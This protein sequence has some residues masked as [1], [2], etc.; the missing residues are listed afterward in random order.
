MKRLVGWLLVVTLLLR[1]LLM[2][3]PVMATFVII[4]AVA[5]GV[6]EEARWRAALGLAVALLLPIAIRGRLGAWLRTRRRPM[7]APDW[8]TFVSLANLVLAGG[9]CFGFADQAGRALRRRGDWFCGESNGAVVRGLRAGLAVSARYLERFDP[10]LEL[11]PVV[12]PPDPAR[13]P[14]GPELPGVTPPEALPTV[15]GWFHPLAGPRRA[16]PL[17]E[18]RR[19][20][21]ARPQPRPAECELGHCGVDLGST[22]G[23]PVFAIGD[24]VIE[25]IER[26]EARG[27]NAGRYVRIGHRDGTVVSRYIHLDSIRE[28]L[29]EGA[30]IRGGELLGRLG[31]SGVEHSGAHLHF[32]LSLRPDGRAG[33]SERYVDPEPLL[34][35]WQLP[36]LPALAQK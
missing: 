11:A 14:Y 13:V 19:F 20:G 28:D 18:S 29:R 23:E 31:R 25:R 33:G 22:I 2:T 32:A 24:G 6:V 9:I 35:R 34:L 7:R 27:G 15:I 10:P 21:A 16:L 12:L 4:T 30:A 1:A 3:L 26:D 36:A 8:G 17:W 5:G